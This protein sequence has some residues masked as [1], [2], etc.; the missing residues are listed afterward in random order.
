MMGKRTR[1]PPDHGRPEGLHYDD[2]DDDD[3]DDD[4]R[5]SLAVVVQTFRSA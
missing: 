1:A 5:V 3:D 2:D 4:G